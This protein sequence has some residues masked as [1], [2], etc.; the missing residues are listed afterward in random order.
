MNYSLN[1]EIERSSM[2]TTPHMKV[3]PANQN[4]KSWVCTTNIANHLRA[5]HRIIEGKEKVEINYSL[6]Q[7]KIDRITYHLIDW[8]IDDM[9][10]FHVVDNQKFQKFIHELESFYSIPCKNSLYKKMSEAISTVEQNL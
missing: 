7:N 1:N 5:K 3:I 10:T 2:P 4:A 9:Q 6:E 8:L